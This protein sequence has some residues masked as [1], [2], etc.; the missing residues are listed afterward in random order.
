MYVFFDIK[1]EHPTKLKNECNCI[2]YSK[3]RKYYNVNELI[4]LYPTIFKGCRSSR[5]FISKN[6]IPSD[7][8]IFA[9]EINGD[10][11]KS[12]GSIKHMKMY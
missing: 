7:K 10:W 12:N 3:K 1:D 5:N 9:K 4:D 8:H 11:S 6:N 2:H